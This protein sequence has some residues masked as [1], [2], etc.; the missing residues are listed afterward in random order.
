MH[1]ETLLSNPRTWVGIAFIIF[2]VIF[3]RRMWQALAKM[4]DNHGQVVRNQLDE[5]A[6]LRS[7]AEAMLVAAQKRR[8]QAEA[9]ANALVE[10]AHRQAAQVAEAARA[11]AEAAASRR[12]RMATER[13][14]AAEKAAVA[15]VRAA[16]VDIATEAASRIMASGLGPDT[17]AAIV[18]RS[19]AGLPTALGRRAA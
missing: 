16:A 18:D 12:E 6:R 17:D 13:I 10:G 15:E 3:G 5:A 11:E 8:V 19:I 2:F 7:E 4:L 14:A 9:E 1:E